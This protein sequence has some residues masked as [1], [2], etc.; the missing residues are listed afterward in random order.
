[1]TLYMHTHNGNLRFYYSPLG[2]YRVEYN[3]VVVIHTTNMER[4]LD[5]YHAL[6]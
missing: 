2:L 3:R 5:L 6:A 4:A 1:M